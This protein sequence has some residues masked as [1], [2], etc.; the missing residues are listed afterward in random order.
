MKSI[1]YIGNK[2]SLHGNTA[3]AIEIL[4]PV[5]ETAGF[6]LHYASS[7]KN[8]IFRFAEMIWKTYAL[9]NRVDYVLIDTYSTQNFWYTV[10]VSKICRTFHIKYIPILHGGNLPNRLK[11]N[12][13]RCKK[14]FGKSYLNVAPSGYLLEA[15][16]DAGFKTI[17]IPNPFDAREF[18]HKQRNVISPKL[19]WVRSFASIYNPEMAIDTLALL[20]DR[21]PDVSL[22]MVGPDKGLLEQTKLAAK[23]RNGNVT[24]TGRL[25]KKEWA[26]LSENFDVF[27][28]TS[29]VDNAPFSIIEAL[30]LG[31][32]VV[33]TD[34]GGIRFLLKDRESAL[35]VADGD[36]KA[37]ADAIA[38]VVNNTAL[39]DHLLLN[40][41]QLTAV[42]DAAEVRKKWLEIL[43]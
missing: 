22:C 12:P 39:Q 4:G 37:M 1:L 10:A 17:Y 29:H 20:K 2:L 34:V 3:T 28:N 31:M 38:E 30:A 19:L 5:L 26:A 27:I 11:N 6:R 24:F 41:K 43:V 40:S 7:R 21:F 13:D 18:P 35:L 42:C 16:K 32:I 14:I 15:F 9:R 8:K 33:S 25:S 23:N 36:S